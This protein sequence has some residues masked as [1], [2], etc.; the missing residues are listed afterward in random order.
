MSD[1]DIKFKKYYKEAFSIAN[2]I[3]DK[4]NETYNG[5]IVTYKDYLKIPNLYHGMVW[6]KCLRMVSLLNG[7]KSNFEALE[8]TL[9]DL[10]NYV[11][12]AYAASMIQ[13]EKE[14]K[15]V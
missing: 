13:N 12:F 8:D 6:N 2:E 14:K 5:D 1:F 4:K 9:I 15:H 7:S 3:H 10:L 11:A